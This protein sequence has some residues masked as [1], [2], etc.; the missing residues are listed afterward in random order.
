MTS[1]FSY[2]S[3]LSSI[4]HDPTI[5]LASNCIRDYFGPTV[6]LVADALILRSDG[7]TLRQ[8]IATIE[9]K[10]DCLRSSRRSDER[11]EIMRLG[12]LRASATSGKSSNGDFPSHASVRAS[13]LTMIQHSVVKVK[14]KM[15]TTTTNIKKDDQ[16]ITKTKTIHI[17][18]IDIDR[19]RLFPRYPRFVEFIK[20]AVGDTAATLVETLLVQG[21][22]RT[23]QAIVLSVEQL[24][25]Q[26][27]DTNNDHRYTNRQ[28]VMENF[29]RLTR[30]GFISIVR[31]MNMDDGEETEFEGSTESKTNTIDEEK[32]DDDGDEDP[33]VVS[34]LRNGPYKNIPAKAIWRVNVDMFHEQLRAVSLGWLVAERY[35]HK[36]Q[37]SGSIVTAALKSAAAQRFG[38]TVVK[39]SSS[40]SISTGSA[41]KISDFETIH[42]FSV[43][44]ILRYLPKAVVQ[45]FEKK[46]GGVVRNIYQTL[47]D[48]THVRDPVVVE[49]VEVA[50][51]QPA[52]SKFQIQARK[53]VEYLRVRIIHQI[54]R[55]SH[56]E[57][58]ARIC[59]ILRLNGYSE[60]DQ[61][62]ELAMA[63]AKDTRELLHRLYRDKYIELFNINQG[64]QHN[65]FSMIYLWGYSRPRC[66]RNARDNVCTALCNMR[67]RRQ[68]EVEVGKD[69]INRA[70]EAEATDENENEADKLMF[71]RFCQGL[72]RLDN[73]A[74]QLDETLMV[75]NDY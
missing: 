32:D 47:V 44:R 57:V 43:D 71:S 55:D 50:P 40:N 56:G 27:E 42:N 21:R 1:K 53:L 45:S 58:A 61:I 41:V 26:Q 22:A 64:K 70:K 6:Q 18:E 59:H 19:A 23:V 74:I 16:P 51:G 63:P 46:E 72:E 49:Q 24:Q 9:T 13:L 62:A 25:H 67:L 28:S 11:Q 38:T 10:T 14:K 3:A 48:L 34:M 12:K 60:S 30:G 33:T 68:K 69:W 36:I 39:T 5:T 73:A 7:A 65:P 52:H 8:I 35:N 31:D 75:L 29:L 2:K 66:A 17:Y 4:N 54:I 15:T 20:K 37:S